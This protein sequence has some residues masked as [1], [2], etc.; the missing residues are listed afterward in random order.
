LHL[1][2]PTI[3]TPIGVSCRT[4]PRS[5]CSDRAMPALAQRLVI[6]E[7]RRGLSTYSIASER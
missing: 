1:D 2:D 4:C 3:I 5:D 6:D 7:N